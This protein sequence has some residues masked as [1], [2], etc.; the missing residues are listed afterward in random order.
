MPLLKL[1]VLGYSATEL[2]ITVTNDSGG[3]LDK[4]LM[5]ELF[6]PTY[7]VDPRIAKAADDGMTDRLKSGLG[8]IVTGP[9]GWSFWAKPGSTVETLMIEIDNDVDQATD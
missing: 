5:I 3:L 4:S 6:P 7:L 8:G 1:T 9:A 2:K